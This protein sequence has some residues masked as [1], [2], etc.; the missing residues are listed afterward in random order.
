MSYK[1]YNFEDGII[2]S[3]RLVKKDKLTSLH[4]IDI[5][6]ML[7][8]KDKLVSII[9]RGKNTVKGE[10]LFKK[11]PGDI[12]ELLNFDQDNE[13]NL[14]MDDGQI[15]IKSPGGKIVDIEVFSNIKKDFFPQLITHIKRTDKK[16][17]KPPREKYTERG[18]TI[19]GI[20][21]IFKIEQELPIGIG[22]KLCNRFGNKGIISIIEKEELMPR[23]P[24]GESCD[25]ILNPLGVINR[26]N[27]GQVYEIYCGL[28]S[29][30][31]SKQMIKLKNKLPIIKLFETI[32]VELDVTKDKKFSKNFILNLKKLDN[33]QFKNMVE[34]IKNNDFFP[35]IIPPFESPSYKQI[36]SV[37]KKLGLKSAYYMTLPDYGIKTYKP[38][39]FGYTYMAKLEHIGEMKLHVRNTGPT[40]G[41]TLQPTGGKG[42]GGGQRFGEHDSYALSIYNCTKVLSEILG[43]LSDDVQTKN[44]ILTEIIQTGN[45]NFRVS[46]QSPTKNLLNSYFIAM[47]L[48]ERR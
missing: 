20:K 46:Q 26:M 1:G 34:Q 2:I 7:D 13:E 15:I 19:K 31:A 28:I 8:Q 9:E 16:Y 41:K 36:I 43:P 11:L 17:K 30:Y 18:K 6:V 3:D 14:D 35:I 37:L 32:M 25:I 21:I 5:E 42:R 45:A 12:N 47:M 10:I 48:D 27:L 22:D 40:V 23:T 38:V 44:E 29:K 4:G 24:W 39:P 33:N